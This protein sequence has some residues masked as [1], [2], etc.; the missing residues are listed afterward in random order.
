[1][2]EH[3][4][5]WQRHRNEI[6]N[7]AGCAAGAQSPAT[8]PYVEY[9]IRYKPAKQFFH[10]PIYEPENGVLKLPALPGL[11]IVLDEAKIESREVL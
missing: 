4:Q 7:L 6:W 2:A 1:M 11:G 9:L 3:K 5:P 8:V 10:N